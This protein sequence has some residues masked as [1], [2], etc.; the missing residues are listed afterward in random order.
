MQHTPTSHSP[1]VNTTF[2]V[3]DFDR[4]LGNTN[5]LHELFHQVIREV[6]DNDAMRQLDSARHAVEDKGGSFDSVGYV[7]DILIQ[8]GK[9]DSWQKIADT[10]VTRANG[11][12][13]LE[14]GAHQL[15]DYLDDHGYLYG[16]VTFGGELWQR[17]KI[18][19]VGLDAVPNMVT[20]TQD[21]GRLLNSWQQSDGSFVIPGA[22]TLNREDTHVA[23]LMLV[24]DNPINF[25]GLHDGIEAFCIK[26][27]STRD[28]GDRGIVIPV[29][30]QTVA[31]LNDVIAI[32]QHDID[33]T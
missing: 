33:K 17:L 2:F 15:I 29:H 22:L 5:A 12:G 26:N 27:D 19:A 10:F 20:D 4:T 18:Q 25:V 31:G 32:L 14:P 11:D 28:W 23:S 24:D 3:L 13:Y 8:A 6:V 16:I 9:S 1:V 30:V 7:Q 21:K